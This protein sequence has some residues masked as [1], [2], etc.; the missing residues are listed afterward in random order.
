MAHWIFL[1]KRQIKS[2]SLQAE[3]HFE[4]VTYSYTEA[5]L[6]NERGM[7]CLCWTIGDS[8]KLTKNPKYL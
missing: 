6:H 5:N 4:W 3:N 7:R 8:F 2:T 1:L